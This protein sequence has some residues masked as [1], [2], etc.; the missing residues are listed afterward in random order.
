MTMERL[1][2]RS[3]E[4]IDRAAPLSFTWNGA[5][6]VGFAGDTIA[7]AIAARLVVPDTA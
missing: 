6:L 2:P 7:S 1:G 3:G 4:V 5:P